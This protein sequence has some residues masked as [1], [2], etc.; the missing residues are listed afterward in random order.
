MN[1]FGHHLREKN[2]SP[3]IPR[4]VGLA[5]GSGAARGWAHI[6]VIEELVSR[7]IEI[8]CVAGTSIG[9]LVGAVYAAGKL[10]VFADVARDLDWQQVLYHFFEVS[11]P[12]SGLIDGTRIVAFVRK[13]VELSGIPDLAIPF[14]AVA[15]DLSSGAEVVIKDGDVLEAV[16]ASIALPGIFTPVSR[17]GRVLV[18]GG[19]VNPVPVN[20]A[21][22]L[23]ADFVIA[24][25]V[26]HLGVADD[27]DQEDADSG[28][29]EI[30]ALPERQNDDLVNTIL[31]NV[32][33][34][35]DELDDSAR[36]YIRQM[37]KQNVLP[38]IFEVLGSS[39]RI[40]EAQ[41]ADARL[42]VDPP[43]LL[44]RPLVG[45]LG[46]MDFHKA[47]EAIWQGQKAMSAAF[48]TGA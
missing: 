20:A 13:F 46:F 42:K 37:M 34:K 18:D 28:Y 31:R 12:R 11:F 24:V 48:D 39:I 21:R 16:R 4:R 1:L 14:C 36:S 29:K 8:E 45:H 30:V 6:G 38:N 3:R 27:Q 26:S 9:S 10:D 41:V 5:L 33:R 44:I 32:R 17:D 40:I 22:A 2:A 7:G 15:T 23:G 19:L 35:F 25:D 47:G 43:D